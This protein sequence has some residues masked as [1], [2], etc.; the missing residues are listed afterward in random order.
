LCVLGDGALQQMLSRI[1]RDAAAHPRPT[2]ALNNAAL[3]LWHRDGAVLEKLDAPQFGR[4]LA[5]SASAGS[6]LQ[7]L[8]AF[9][10]GVHATHV[11]RVL[12]APW[13]VIARGDDGRVVAALHQ[14]RHIVALAFRPDSVLSLRRGVGA[15]AQ[16]L[17]LHWL[18]R[19]AA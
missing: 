14:G 12:P 11:A 1:D 8:G 5:C 2:L 13:Q 10:V 4:A 3:A 18:S 17:A 19:P 15:A 6:L 9:T 16:R 7:T